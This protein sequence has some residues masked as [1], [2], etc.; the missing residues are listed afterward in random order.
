MLLNAS[1]QAKLELLK[2]TTADN[3][4]RARE[5]IVVFRTKYPDQDQLIKRLT[6]L[7]VMVGVNIHV[8]ASTSGAS[9]SV[10]TGVV[11]SGGALASGDHATP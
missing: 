11:V 10:G 6:D 3:D 9:V 4:K 7:A 5:S 2:K 1:A 8:V